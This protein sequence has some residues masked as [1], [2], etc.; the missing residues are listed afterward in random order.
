MT[1]SKYSQTPRFLTLGGGHTDDRSLYDH[2]N[3]KRRH[4]GG[5]ADVQ[6]K[7]EEEGENRQV[8][9]AVLPKAESQRAP[10]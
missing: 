9:D 1:K 10:G 8:E 6:R 4:V 2:L 5:G 3:C 7:G